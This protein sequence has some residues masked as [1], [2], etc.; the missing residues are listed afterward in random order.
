VYPQGPRLFTTTFPRHL[1][2]IGP[3]GSDSH[4]HISGIRLDGG[5]SAD[6]YTNMG[7]ADSDGIVV[8]KANVEI[9]HNE[10]YRWRGAAVHILDGD[11]QRDLVNRLNGTTVRVHDN[12]IHHNEHPTGEICCGHGA[13]YGV[14]VSHGAYAQVD[15]NVFDVNRHAM[16][17]DGRPGTG[18]F[19]VDNLILSEGSPNSHFS[20]THQIDMHGYGGDCSQYQCGQAGEYE[21]VAYNTVWFVRGPAVKLRGTP[22]DKMEVRHN[23]FAHDN[24]WNSTWSTPALVENES[25]LVESDNLVGVQVGGDARTVCD[26]DGDAVADTF[27]ATGVTWW[28]Q[29]SLL[30]GRYVYLNES[31]A[32][33]SA[34][35]LGDANGDGLCDVTALGHAYLTDPASVLNGHPVTMPFLIGA[36]EQEAR[37]YVA[38]AGMTVGSVSYVHSPVPAGLVIGQDPHFGYVKSAGWAV[39]LVVSTGERTVPNVLGYEAA[40]AE[41]AIIAAGLTVGTPSYT[42]TCVDPGSVQGQNPSGGTLVSPGSTVNLTISTCSGGGGGGDGG[43]DPLPK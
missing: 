2:D 23:A 22:T 1:F 42:N 13:G 31:G 3:S 10:V 16:T 24:L 40:S 33:G 21:Y 18:Y 8:E 35:S 7:E 12:Y 17:G 5:S 19:F 36:S 38:A 28:F 4:E 14:E 9:D 29:S 32:Y 11:D 34:V 25:G 37:G 43:G 27:H 39:N 20:Y 26:F 15:R 41:D 6:P 30:G